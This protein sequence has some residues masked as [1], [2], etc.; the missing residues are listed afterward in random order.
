MNR[1]RVCQTFQTVIIKF[2]NVWPHFCPCLLKLTII[3]TYLLHFP[4]Y[5]LLFISKF[6]IYNIFK[7][8]LDNYQNLILPYTHFLR[9]IKISTFCSFSLI[10]VYILFFMKCICYCTI[11]FNFSILIFFGFVS[12]NIFCRS[13]FKD[14]WDRAGRSSIA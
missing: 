4:N 5:I 9:V 2:S 10:R 8:C 13:K 1:L 7:Q 11:C 12:L 14:F 6:F 3:K